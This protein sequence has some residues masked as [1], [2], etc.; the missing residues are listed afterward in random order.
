MSEKAD[1]KSNAPKFL[2]MSSESTSCD[3]WI[4]KL[5]KRQDGRNQLGKTPASVSDSAN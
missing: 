5:A 2:E 4:A 1:E 3:R